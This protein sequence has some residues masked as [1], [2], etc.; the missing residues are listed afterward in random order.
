M[1]GKIILVVA[2][3]ILSGYG[4][5]RY[6]HE[7]YVAGATRISQKDGMKIV[8]VPADQFLVDGKPLE[9]FWIDQTEVT[10]AMFVSFLND[11]QST[12]IIEGDHVLSGNVFLYYLCHECGDFTR[13]THAGID[14]AVVEKYADHPVS[15]VTWFGAD[16]Y[17]QWAG[18]H[19]P[20]A[21]EWLKAANWNPTLQKQYQFPWGNDAP[22]SS[23][24]NFGDAAGNTSKIGSYPAGASFYG[25][26]DMAGNVWEWVNVDP[27][28]IRG[29]SWFSPV[30]ELLSE[31]ILNYGATTRSGNYIGFRCAVGE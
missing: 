2:F 5:Y 17:C 7:L 10:N 1:M 19:L 11:I 13:I 21:D 18:R 4:I 3:F 14:F 9:A 16:V 24:V 26:V 30:D 12:I 23:L 31:N 15:T 25:V 8:Y 6:S 29:G 28:A 27:P 22:S 20:S